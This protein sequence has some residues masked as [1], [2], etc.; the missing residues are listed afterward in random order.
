[1]YIY[2][3]EDIGYNG[4][5]FNHRDDL[6]QHLD[7][8]CL[9][10]DDDNHF[11]PHELADYLNTPRYAR[12]GSFYDRDPSILN[13]YYS[14]YARVPCDGPLNAVSAIVCERETPRGPVVIVKDCPAHEWGAL[15]TEIDVDELAK[16]LWYYHRSGVSAETEFGERT[17]LR[18]LIS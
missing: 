2:T 14:M 9:A 13:W 10:V 17:L 8:G 1:M 12:I 16:T 6:R 18:M 4:G 15:K 11:L 7:G 5:A 3:A